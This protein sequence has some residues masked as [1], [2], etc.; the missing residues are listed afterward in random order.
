MKLTDEQKHIIAQAH[1]RL[2]RAMQSE[3]DDELLFLNSMAAALE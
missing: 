3:F 2:L 1:G